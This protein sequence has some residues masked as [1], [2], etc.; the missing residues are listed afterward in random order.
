MQPWLRSPRGLFLRVCGPRG[1]GKR[2]FLRRQ[3]AELAAHGHPVCD[4]TRDPTPFDL[5]DDFR[6]L[7]RS[8]LAGAVRPPV[9][10]MAVEDARRHLDGIWA[11][12]P[13]QA[14]IV[15]AGDS[16][17]PEPSPVPSSWMTHNWQFPTPTSGEWHRWIAASV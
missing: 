12:L 17:E 16:V 7:L 11:L 6:P 9:V 4:L 13:G 8:R 14:L 3:L 10:L 5:P 15:V 2:R 1:A